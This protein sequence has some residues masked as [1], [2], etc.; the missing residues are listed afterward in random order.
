MQTLP[1][2]HANV[3]FVWVQPPLASQPSLVHALPSSHCAAVP[4]QTPPWQ[5]STDVHAEPSLH[6]ALL[7]A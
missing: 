4:T 6:G 2:S 3:L 7:L 1:S 5:V